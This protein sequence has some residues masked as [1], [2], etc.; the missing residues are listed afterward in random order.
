RSVNGTQ[1]RRGKRLQPARNVAGQDLL[2]ESGFTLATRERAY[3]SDKGSS[4]QT[5]LRPVGSPGLPPQ[6]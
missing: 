3:L 1:F 5:A 4:P 6:G 2:E